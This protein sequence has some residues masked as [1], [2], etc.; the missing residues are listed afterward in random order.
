HGMTGHMFVEQ[1]AKC[2]GILRKP[3]PD[4]SAQTLSVIDGS[5]FQ[6][7]PAR[8]RDDFIAGSFLLVENVPI[9]KFSGTISKF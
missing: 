2:R 3:I 7:Y 5:G 1:V 4:R 9:S 6:Q 8:T